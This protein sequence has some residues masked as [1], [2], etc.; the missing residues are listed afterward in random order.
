MFCRRSSLLGTAA[1]G[2]LEEHLAD[3]AGH[4]LVQDLGNDQVEQPLLLS[5][6]QS[7]VVV[8][9]CQ[10][11]KR[12]GCPSEHVQAGAHAVR[13][14]AQCIHTVLLSHDQGVGL[15]LLNE[16]DE[17]VNCC[18]LQGDCSRYPTVSRR[19]VKE[20]VDGALSQNLIL[21]PVQLLEEETAELLYPRVGQGGQQ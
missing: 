6:E 8:M 21:R 14:V 20:Q 12:V 7:L 10:V 15:G 18:V 13:V 19:E 11:V 3:D 16:A 1:S 17:E 4:S 5:H 2:H 9:S